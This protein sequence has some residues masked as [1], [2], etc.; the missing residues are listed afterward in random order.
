MPKTPDERGEDAVVIALGANQASAIGPPQATLAAAL[1][2]LEGSDI[3]IAAVAPWIT[4]PAWPPGN[5]ADYTN[6][7][8][9]LETRLAPLD[10]LHRLLA[11]EAALGR[12][13]GA[14]WGARVCDLDLLCYGQLVLPR[15][16]GWRALA[17][18]PA[19]VSAVR[20]PEL[21]LPHPRL[22]GRA[23]ALGPLCAVAPGWRHPVLGLS[24]QAMLDAL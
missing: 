19:D 21:A 18:L 16:P 12:V 23:F 9:R 10:L 15:A 11:V 13:R 17:A 3:R 6:G 22:A 8:A 14:R 20:Q 7:A 5:G 4:T 2:A 1:Q 24:P